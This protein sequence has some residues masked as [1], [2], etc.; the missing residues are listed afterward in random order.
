MRLESSSPIRNSEGSRIKASFQRLKLRQGTTGT[1]ICKCQKPRLTY[2][3]SA[4]NCTDIDVSSC[5]DSNILQ[6]LLNSERGA[7]IQ[8]LAGIP[9]DEVHSLLTDA[10]EA[11]QFVEQIQQ[12]QVP[13]II[14]NIPQEA[15]AQITDVISIALLVPSAIIG[16]ATAAV[17]DAASV[18]DDIEDGSITSAIEALPSDIYTEITMGWSDLTAGLTD[19]W[20]DATNGIKCLFDNC[21]TSVPSSCTVPAS[22]IPITTSNGGGNG[23]Y[24]VNTYGGSP[25]VTTPGHG[26]DANPYPLPTLMATATPSSLNYGFGPSGSGA[27]WSGSPGSRFSG[28]GS[29]SSGGGSDIVSNTAAAVQEFTSL[30]VLGAFVLGILST[31]LLI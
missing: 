11:K 29:N 18:I 13:S 24:P 21:P 25:P 17:S 1:L 23:G 4:E 6:G 27:P 8:K 10:N 16:F 2:L 26:T 14:Q 20:D 19:A 30:K 31:A 12:G 15:L 9:C 5:R 28:S 7:I 3:K 22:A